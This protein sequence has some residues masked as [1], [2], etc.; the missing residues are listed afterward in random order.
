[1]SKLEYVAPGT[2]ALREQVKPE[3]EARK[4]REIALGH[5]ALQANLIDEQ[6]VRLKEQPKEV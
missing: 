6:E 5:I 4:P 3:I 2:S 1:M